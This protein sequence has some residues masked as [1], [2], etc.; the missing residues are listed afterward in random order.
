M[1]V[2]NDTST[3]ALV[4]VPAQAA[5]AGEAQP[6][7]GFLQTVPMLIAI[8]AIFY[9]FLIRPQNKARE[10]HQKLVGGLK[11]GDE[12]LTEGGLY[13]TIHEVHEDRV[14]LELAPNVRV[15]FAKGSVA[16]TA[17]AD[18]ADDKKGG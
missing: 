15:A 14:F 9:F 11:K 10:A 13:G 17:S 2:T 1:P 7:A 4:I 3:D 8:F 12:V 5:P 6:Q 16:S 18:D